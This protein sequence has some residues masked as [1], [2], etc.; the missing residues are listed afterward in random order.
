MIFNLFKESILLKISFIAI[1]LFSIASTPLL[2]EEAV[3]F[4]A[5][6]SDIFSGE[7]QDESIFNNKLGN[8]RTLGASTQLLIEARMLFYI[9]NQDYAGLASYLPEIDKASDNWVPGES[10]IFRDT[11]SYEGMRSAIHAYNAQ[12]HNDIDAFEKYS[13][14]AFWLDPRLAPIL[15]TWIHNY[16]RVS[17]TS[18]IQ[19][20]LDMII[21][22]S[23]GNMTTLGALVKGKKALLLDF[24]ATWCGP[25]IALMPALI[26]KAKKLDPQGV[27]V[28]GMNIESV[29]KAEQFRKKENINFTWLVEPDKNPLS[30][31]LMIDSIPRMILIDNEGNVL[32]NGH[33]NDPSFHDVITT[34]RVKL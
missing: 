33:P 1:G 12:T 16:R 7:I 2:G 19:I 34:L 13:K 4:D 26:E 9:V 20:P 14:N 5:I 30:K 3:E 25:C 10:K 11:K 27:L 6:I 15:T 21:Q 29:S 28:A 32:Y 17:I 24:W 23:N 31:L 18:N 8:A 22:Y